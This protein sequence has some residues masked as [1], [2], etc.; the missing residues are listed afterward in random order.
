MVYQV[1]GINKNTSKYAV[2]PP[3][4]YQ[5]A[6]YCNKSITICHEINPQTRGL[7]EYSGDQGCH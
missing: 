1:G 3:G 5:F 2:I 6:I 4:I 7:Q